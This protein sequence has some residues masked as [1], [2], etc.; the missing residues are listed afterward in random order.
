MCIYSLPDWA[1]DFYPTEASEEI[2]YL[3]FTLQ[4]YTPP[5]ARLR[6]GFLLK[7]IL[8]HCQRK[9]LNKLEPNYKA[10]VYSSHDVT[11][12]HVLKGL[13][14]F[15]VKSITLFLYVSNK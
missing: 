14:L 5:L 1:K 13:G 6:I 7:E 9:I 10:F 2:Y 15:E 12:A 11:V 4:A 8:R 3:A